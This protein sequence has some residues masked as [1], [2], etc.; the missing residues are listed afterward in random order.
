MMTT[1]KH[2]ISTTDVQQFKELLNSVDG[3]ATQISTCSN[4]GNVVYT[5]VIFEKVE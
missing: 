4:N 3:F 1:K 2:V 5:A